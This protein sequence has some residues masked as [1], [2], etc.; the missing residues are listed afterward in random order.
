MA[1]DSN[2]NSFQRLRL[3]T[4][5]HKHLFNENR[6]I[7]FKQEKQFAGTNWITQ[8]MGESNNRRISVKL[9]T[10]KIKLI[11]VSTVV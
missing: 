1:N 5:K 11:G 9:F 6:K 3:K 4:L 2:Y 7:L 8:Y 10:F